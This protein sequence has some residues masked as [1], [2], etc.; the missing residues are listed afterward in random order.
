MPEKRQEDH[1]ILRMNPQQCRLRDSTYSAE[2][3][4]DLEFIKGQERIIAKGENGKGHTAIGRIPI[5]LRSDR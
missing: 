2:I 4:V 1:K 5:M 3:R